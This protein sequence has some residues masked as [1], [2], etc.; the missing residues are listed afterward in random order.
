[1]LRAL[2]RKSQREQRRSIVSSNRASVDDAKSK[3]LQELAD[4]EQTRHLAVAQLQGIHRQWK[5][6]VEVRRRRKIQQCCLDIQRLYRGLLGRRIALEKKRQLLRVV[7]TKFAM[8]ELKRKCTVLRDM[9]PWQELRDPSTGH[10]FYLYKP[11]LD[12]QWA[13]PKMFSEKFSC[14]WRDCTIQC[15]SL[16]ELEAHRRDAHWWHCDACFEKNQV[17][18]FPTCQQCDN[19]FSGTGKTLQKAY[20]KNWET[21][22]MMQEKIPDP[23]D[24]T[25]FKFIERNTLTDLRPMS[26]ADCNFIDIRKEVLADLAGRPQTVAMKIIN[27]HNTL[28]PRARTTKIKLTGAQRRAMRESQRISGGTVD[29]DII[30]QIQDPEDFDPVRR[31]MTLQEYITEQREIAEEEEEER[32][33]LI[34]DEKQEALALAEGREYKAKSPIKKKKKRSKAAARSS[35]KKDADA[36]IASAGAMRPSTAGNLSLENFARLRGHLRSAHQKERVRSSR[37]SGGSGGGGDTGFEKPQDDSE[38]TDA[39]SSPLSPALDSKME[40]SSMMEMPQDQFTTLAKEYYGDQV[41]TGHGTRKYASGAMYTGMLVDNKHHGE[42]CM[43][44][45]NDDQYTGDWSVGRRVGSGSFIAKSGKRYVGQWLRN[46]RHGWGQLTH[47]NGEMYVG[48]WLDGRMNGHGVLTSANGD[49]YEGAWLNGKYHGIGRFSKA[50]GHTFIGMCKDGKAWGKGIIEYP[51]GERYRGDWVNDRREGRGICT[52][53]DGGHYTG[54]WMRGKYDGFG[55]LIQ[56]SGEKYVGGWFS[57][58]RDGYGKATFAN[59]DV[60][61]GGWERDKVVG[62]GVMYYNESGNMYDGLWKYGKRHGIGTFGEVVVVAACCCLLLP[63][64]ACCCLLLPVCC[65]S[66]SVACICVCRC[67]VWLCLVVLGLCF[68]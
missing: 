7:P 43:K 25:A 34:E 20:E 57:G 60:Y 68:V 49:R 36:R 59:G 1:M 33:Q 39:L 19:Q 40:D 4:E 48:E 46:V 22:L 41:K 62:K 66:V 37:G 26:A 52:Y 2:L 3:F 12:S 16:M 10:V 13:A 65:V 28:W 27:K 55:T 30:A 24:P 5:A 21:T 11:T 67:C 64:A 50:A 45:A 63:V 9:G 47:P 17:D 42:G 38:P 15:E 56:G 23:L 14:T 61:V 18:N 51:T 54:S 53:P 6:R 29:P 31:G 44:Y 32:L 58:M 35:A 8:L